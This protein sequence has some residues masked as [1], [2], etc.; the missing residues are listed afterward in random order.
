MA[1][2]ITVGLTEVSV[3]TDLDVAAAKRLGHQWQAN[4]YDN[5]SWHVIDHDQVRVNGTLQPGRRKGEAR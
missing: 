2:L 4:N 5:P 1:T 3:I